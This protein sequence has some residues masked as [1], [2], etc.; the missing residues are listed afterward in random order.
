MLDRLMNEVIEP[1]TVSLNPTVRGL[2]ESEHNSVEFQR[3]LARRLEP[4]STAHTPLADITSTP[5]SE[6]G[7]WA[8]SH[9]PKTPMTAV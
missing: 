6:R 9:R 5:M 3:Q 8:L 7:L 2:L 1:G 4:A